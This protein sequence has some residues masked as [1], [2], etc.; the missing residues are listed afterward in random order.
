MAWCRRNIPSEVYLMVRP[1]RCLTTLPPSRISSSSTFL[2]RK[3]HRGRSVS[4]LCSLSSVLTTH[5][6]YTPSPP[7]IPVEEEFK[8]VYTAPLKGAV[9]A[10]KIFSVCTAA[11]AALGG[12]VLVCL[13]NPGVSL[14]GRIA[15]SSLVML[16]GFSTT[17]ILHW[18]TKG[19]IIR[20]EY[21]K[22]SQTVAAYTCNL[23]ARLKRNEFH[24]SDFGPSPNTAGFSTFQARGKSYFLHS[25]V[26][27]NTKLLSQLVGPCRDWTEETLQDKNK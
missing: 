1:I 24:I 4:S 10:V 8:V 11:S 22:Q 15:I 5:R 3:F 9:R 19:Y 2:P 7:P 20:M 12:P 16:V 26:L 21:H 17:A 18:L 14:M 27:G 25:E 13:G 6:Y 23:L